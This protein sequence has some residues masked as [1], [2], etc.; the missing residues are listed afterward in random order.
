MDNAE[1]FTLGE[2][3]KMLK[4]TYHTVWL[5]AKAGRIRSIRVGRCLRIH[6]SEVELIMNGEKK[7]NY[8]TCRTEPDR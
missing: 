6:I 7:W 4:V 3:A 8:Q 1:L 2:V 5:W